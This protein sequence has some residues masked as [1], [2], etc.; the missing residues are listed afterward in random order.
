MPVGN[1][2][3]TTNA[4]VSLHNALPIDVTRVR[5]TIGAQ[6]GAMTACQLVASETSPTLST[7]EGALRRTTQSE[8]TVL[9]YYNGTLYIKE[10]YNSVVAEG[11]G[12]AASVLRRAQTLI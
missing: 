6:S 7:S 5:L 3:H 4:S 8:E 11:V 10:S 9:I 2:Y 1:T 12:G